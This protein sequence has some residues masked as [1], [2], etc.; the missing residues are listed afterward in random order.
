MPSASQRGW[1]ADSGAWGVRVRC[2]P[3]RWREALESGR[4]RRDRRTGFICRASGQMSAM[5]RF[6]RHRVA[7]D[8]KVRSLLYVWRFRHMSHHPAAAKQPPGSL[9]QAPER[10]AQVCLRLKTVPGDPRLKVPRP[11]DRPWCSVLTEAPCRRSPP[12]PHAA[13]S[14]QAVARETEHA[15]MAACHQVGDCRR[16]GTI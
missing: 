8:A 4:F 13:T 10:E 11:D 14:G 16:T 2:S 3:C 5:L 12:V 6:I 1:G 9:H 7:V 15:L